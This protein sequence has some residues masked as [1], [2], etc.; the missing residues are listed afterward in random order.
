MNAT[1][2]HNVATLQRLYRSH[3]FS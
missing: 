3:N 1:G 2:R